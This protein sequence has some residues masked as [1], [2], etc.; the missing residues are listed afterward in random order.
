M[1][2][3]NNRR[4]F[5]SEALIIYSKGRNMADTDESFSVTD[6]N[7]DEKT[8]D[9]LNTS[10]Q[11]ISDMVDDFIPFVTQQE[12]S[13]LQY[14]GYVSAGMSVQGFTPPTRQIN[15]FG[16]VGTSYWLVGTLNTN[17]VLTFNISNY[18]TINQPYRV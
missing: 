13:V 2:N 8:V 1:V 14:N 17:G 7:T 3:Q 12:Y 11:S 6:L 9:A 10:F 16:V 15:V 4:K 18:V 5:K